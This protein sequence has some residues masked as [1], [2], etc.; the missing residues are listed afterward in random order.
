MANLSDNTEFK[1]IVDDSVAA[2]VAEL[3]KTNTRGRVD[4]QIS[5]TVQSDDSVDASVSAVSRTAS[6]VT[7]VGPVGTV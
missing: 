4:I 5:L 3:S 6:A 2:V 1:K 7:N